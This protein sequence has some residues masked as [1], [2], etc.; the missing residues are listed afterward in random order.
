MKKKIKFKPPYTVDICQ[1]RFDYSIVVRDA[2]A[3][4]VASWDEVVSMVE[5]GFF[6][7]RNLAESVIRYLVDMK[8]IESEKM[9][10]GFKYVEVLP[11]FEEI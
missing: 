7:E 11:D 5:D 8:V 3:R 10:N 1:E 2:K 4:E 9:W 6:T